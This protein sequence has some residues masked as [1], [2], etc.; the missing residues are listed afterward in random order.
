[1]LPALWVIMGSVLPECLAVL[2]RFGQTILSSDDKIFPKALILT[3]MAF[4]K[5]DDTAEI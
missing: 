4:L 5:G 1:M 3:N 2:L